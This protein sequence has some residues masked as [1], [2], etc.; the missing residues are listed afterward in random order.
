VALAAAV[1]ALRLVPISDLR[2]VVGPVAR[3][4]PPVAAQG[5]PAQRRIDPAARRGGDLRA[6][7]AQGAGGL[8]RDRAGLDWFA[9]TISFKG[10]VLEGLEVAFIV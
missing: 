10:V 5:D 4:R 2:L 8:G 9:F 6:R 1:A 3:L 7:A